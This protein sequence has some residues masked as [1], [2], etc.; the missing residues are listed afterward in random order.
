[1]AF[2]RADGILMDAVKG[3]AE[4]PFEVEVAKAPEP[5][6]VSVKDEAKEEERAE[7]ADSHTEDSPHDTP[8]ALERLKEWLSGWMKTV[9]E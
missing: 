6:V 3:I 5:A 8:T 7:D 4:L 9:T 1:M 2:R